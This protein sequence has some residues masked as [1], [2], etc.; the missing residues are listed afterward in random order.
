M[1]KSDAPAGPL[2][3]HVQHWLEEEVAPLAREA[4]ARNR[5]VLSG[6]ESKARFLEEFQKAK[7]ESVPT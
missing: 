2:P 1:E 4:M 6:K 5:R 3:A 7:N